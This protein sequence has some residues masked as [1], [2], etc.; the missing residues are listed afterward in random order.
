MHRRQRRWCESVVIERVFRH[1]AADHDNEYMMIDSM[2]VRA[3]ADSLRAF[4]AVDLRATAQIR[5]NPTRATMPPINWS[6]YKE[7]HQVECF[8]NK[9]KR[10]LCR[11]ACGQDAEYR[12]FGAQDTQ[13]H[14]GRIC[15]GYQ[16]SSRG[17]ENSHI[18][19]PESDT[20]RLTM[21]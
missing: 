4:I 10:L 15:P 14:V 11:H 9:L 21:V 7:R 3:H 5:A 19:C 20:S 2:I 13:L 8:F 17:I 6:L 1:L 16:A 12:H 18:G